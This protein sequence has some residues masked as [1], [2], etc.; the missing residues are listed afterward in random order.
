MAEGTAETVNYIEKFKF[1]KIVFVKEIYD[2]TKKKDSQ[3]KVISDLD[4]HFISFSQKMTKR[5]REE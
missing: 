2:D 5:I 1:W 3:K 4:E